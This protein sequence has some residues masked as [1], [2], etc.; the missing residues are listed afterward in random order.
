MSSIDELL[1]EIFCKPD[2]LKVLLLVHILFSYS[3]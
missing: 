2:D 1:G 3:Y